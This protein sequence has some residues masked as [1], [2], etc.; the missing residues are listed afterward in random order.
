MKPTKEL[1]H[2]INEFEM[3]NFDLEQPT[4]F[5]TSKRRYYTD[6]K[7]LAL[8]QFIWDTSWQKQY[9]DDLKMTERV[10]KKVWKK[11]STQTAKEIFEELE[12]KDGGYFIWG[13]ERTPLS[14][15]KK[16]YMKK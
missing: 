14:K 6:K 3:D 9:A 16:K 15:L 11:A 7:I 12:S 1:E 5:N 10:C 8:A 4:K 13:V 2:L